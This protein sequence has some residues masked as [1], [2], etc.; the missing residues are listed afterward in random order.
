MPLQP[1]LLLLLLPDA[2]V[3][4]WLHQA[5]LT[6]ERSAGELLVVKASRVFSSQ[7]VLQLLCDRCSQSNSHIP[8]FLLDRI[9]Y[10]VLGKVGGL[11]AGAS[12]W[13]GLRC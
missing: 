9:L 12:Y 5:E 8:L 2:E 1:P 4:H 11:T 3:L 10:T 13:F 6:E 7:A